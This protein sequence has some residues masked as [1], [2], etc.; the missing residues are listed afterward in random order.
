MLH[1]PPALVACGRHVAFLGVSPASSG[2]IDPWIPS[3][4]ALY[5]LHLDKLIWC[6]PHFPEYSA[7]VPIKIMPV[8]AL[9]VFVSTKKM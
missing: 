9:G 7:V 8:I 6:K 5:K 4:K 2:Q 3:G 1:H